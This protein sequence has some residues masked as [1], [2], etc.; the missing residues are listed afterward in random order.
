MPLI[1]IWEHMCRSSGAGACR[2][3][4]ERVVAKDALAL[5]TKYQWMHFVPLMLEHKAGCAVLVV[6]LGMLF[7][8][9]FFDFQNLC[10]NAQR[11]SL[12]PPVCTHSWSQP[13][14]S[15]GDAVEA[16]WCDDLATRLLARCVLFLCFCYGVCVCV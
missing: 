6:R 11:L 5:C 8:G 3:L 1:A 16:N 12:V 13:G 10:R 7:F 2:A 14:W 9:G 15:L 4:L